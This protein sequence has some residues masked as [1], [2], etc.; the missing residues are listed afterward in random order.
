[1]V[2]III[3][4]FK[5]VPNFHRLCYQEHFNTKVWST[6]HIINVM[7]IT[8]CYSILRKWKGKR[9]FQDFCNSQW[10]SSN[11]LYNQI[12]V[13]LVALS[14]QNHPFH[15]QDKFKYVANFHRLCYQRQLQRVDSSSIW[16]VGRC[17]WFFYRKQTKSS[18]LYLSLS[19]SCIYPCLCHCHFVGLV[20][21]TQHLRIFKREQTMASSLK[22]LRFVF[23]VYFQSFVHLK[24]S[25]CQPNVV[26][27]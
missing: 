9:G 14:Q 24:L 13:K 20:M 5:H 17:Q 3:V 11:Y 21:S 23:F 19:L 22:P 2:N 8:R 10:D 25:H 7:L 27:H 12:L 15:T 26:K 1:M 6:E 18:Y 16:R 4:K